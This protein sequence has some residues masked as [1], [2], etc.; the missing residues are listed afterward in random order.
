MFVSRRVHKGNRVLAF[1]FTFAYEIK[2]FIFLSPERLIK[3][4]KQFVLV[5]WGQMKEAS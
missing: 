3:A 1:N 5:A 4:D 2:P